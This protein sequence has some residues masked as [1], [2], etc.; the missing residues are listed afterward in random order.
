MRYKIM[1]TLPDMEG[2]PNFDRN[3]LMYLYRLVQCV[4]LKARSDLLS[5]TSE[6][7]IYSIAD[8]I[9]K[10]IMLYSLLKILVAT[11]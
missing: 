8:E 4:L 2:V 3:Q 11:E 5:M 9:P 6:E 1:P 7:E 10:W